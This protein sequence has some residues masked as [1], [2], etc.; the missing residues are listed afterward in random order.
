MFQQRMHELLDN[1]KSNTICSL[2]FID[3]DHFKEFN[4]QLGHPAGDEALRAIADCLRECTPPTALVARYGGEEFACLLPGVEPAEAVQIAERM[5]L[6]IMQRPI[7]LPGRPDTAQATISAG[8]AAAILKSEADIHQLL[9]AADAAL[10]RA[11][12][13]GRNCVRT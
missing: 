6:D 10:Y 3:V 12:S 11:K 9:R 4:D 13:E 7:P 5:R 1:E 8:V 2:A